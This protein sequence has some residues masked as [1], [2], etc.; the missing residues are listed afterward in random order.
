MATDHS[1]YTLLLLCWTGA[2]QADKVDDLWM[3]GAGSALPRDQLD[4]A[5]WL[6]ELGEG[7]KADALLAAWVAVIPDTADLPEGFADLGADPDLL[8]AILLQHLG[9]GDRKG[10]PVLQY[11]LDQDRMVG[12]RVFA[13]LSDHYA[14]GPGQPIFSGL[15]IGPQVSSRLPEAR[16]ANRAARLR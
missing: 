8:V 14:G 15:R 11:W 12:W 16:A 4:R 6:Y 9:R 13:A 5:L 2:A 1:T 3:G 10:L 7:T